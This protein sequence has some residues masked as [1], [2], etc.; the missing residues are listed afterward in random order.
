MCAIQPCVKKQLNRLFSKT[1]AFAVNCHKHLINPKITRRC[2]E[3]NARK[4]R[5]HSTA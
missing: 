5:Y 3:T 2:S 1:A 4:S